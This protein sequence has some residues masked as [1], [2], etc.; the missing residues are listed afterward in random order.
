MIGTLAMAGYLAWRLGS[1]LGRSLSSALLGLMTFHATFAVL[2]SRPYLYAWDYLDA[3]GFLLFANFVAAGTRWPWF[4]ALFV[5]MIL[6]RDSAQFI[7]L[8]LVLDVAARRSLRRE[9]FRRLDPSETAQVLAGVAC[10]LVGVLVVEGLRRALL[11]K[12]TLVRSGPDP[13][14][15]FHWYLGYNFEVL[16]N[17]LTSF[18]REFPFLVVIVLVACVA[19]C[20]TIAFSRPE[21]FLALGLTFA[22]FAV[23][24]MMFSYVFE[25]RVFVALTP[26][27]TM[28]TLVIA[29]RGRAT[30][31]DLTMVDV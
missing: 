16:L 17:S 29:E 19:A 13:G 12:E 20:L 6:N 15:Y 3:I 18:D 23:S 31:R 1:T 21:R 5:V 11:I 26:L 10:M 2:L 7:A 28:G 27:L 24:I 14:T 4:V 8:W 22:A 30:P 25:T 9:A